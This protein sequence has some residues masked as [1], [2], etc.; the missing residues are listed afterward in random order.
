MGSKKAPSPP[1]IAPPQPSAEEKRLQQEQAKLI[2]QLTGQSNIQFAQSQEDRGKSN[3]FLDR[4]NSGDFGLTPDEERLAQSLSDQFYD[5]G[6]RNL[7]QGSNKE[8]FDTNRKNTIASLV[9]R[10]L[11][12]SSSGTELLGQL[13]KERM[14]QFGDLAGQSALQR[15][16]LQKDIFDKK[17][18]LN[19]DI[20]RSLRGDSSAGSALSGQLANSAIGGASNLSGQLRQQRM[21]AFNVDVQN[22]QAQYQSKLANFNNRQGFGGIGGAIGTALGAATGFAFG[23]PVGGLFGS[24]IGGG[25]GRSVGGFF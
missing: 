16:G 3:Q 25:I 4:I 19:F 20:F 24:T 1:R 9:D 7:T 22:Q 10:G 14:R 15:L 6:V 13:E 12:N 11:L 18:A 2:S 21:D 5:L 8:I 23:G 17:L